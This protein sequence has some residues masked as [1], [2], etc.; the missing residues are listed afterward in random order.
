MSKYYHG[1]TRANALAI[2]QGKDKSEALNIWNV[3]DDDYLYLHDPERLVSIGDCEEEDSEETAIRYAF[4]SGHVAAVAAPSPQSE[5]IVLCFE[6]PSEEVEDDTSCEW[7]QHCGRISS[8]DYKTSFVCAYSAKVNPKLDIFLLSN[9]VSNGYFNARAL[10]DETLKAVEA[11]SQVDFF[12]ETEY[13][14]KEVDLAQD[15][16]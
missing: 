13:D 2:L 15:L 6:F 12:P 4:E 11:I 9:V 16:L 7:M 14:W 1:T 3:S 5:V 10:D 8:D